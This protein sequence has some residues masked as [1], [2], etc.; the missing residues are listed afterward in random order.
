MYEVGAENIASNP[1]FSTSM[2]DTK[3]LTI[4]DIKL[5]VTS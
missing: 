2:S 1:T 3:V 5:K 4:H